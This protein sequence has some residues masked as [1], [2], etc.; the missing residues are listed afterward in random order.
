MYSGGGGLHQVRRIWKI[1]DHVC[2]R[3]TTSPH[4]S[5]GQTRL[6]TQQFAA[7]F[8]IFSGFSN[9]PAELLISEENFCPLNFRSH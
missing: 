9:I 2:G 4:I 1:L 3:R 8:A 5:T 7:I 6:Y